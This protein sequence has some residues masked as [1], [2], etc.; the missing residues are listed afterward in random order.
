MK[1]RTIA[2]IAVSVVAIAI[3]LLL[4]K[5]RLT[6]PTPPGYDQGVGAKYATELAERMQRLSL[7]L[8][9]LG[10]V[11]VTLGGVLAIAG[12]VLGSGPL[13]EDNRNFRAVL[14]AQRGLVCAVFAVVLGGVGWQCMDRSASATKTASIATAA[15]ETATIIE[16]DDEGDK[17]AYKACVKAKSA[18]LEGRMNS[19]RLQSIIDDLTPSADPK[20]TA[21]NE[22]AEGGK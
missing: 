6:V 1:K 8:L 12:A 2:Y 3:V 15:I 21:E 9:I 4:W 19:D 20:N 5:I 10:W 18:W 13:T 14:A 17:R 11:S 22:A 7:V 16:G